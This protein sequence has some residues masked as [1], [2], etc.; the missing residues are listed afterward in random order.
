MVRKAGHPTL[1]KTFTSK[2]KAQ[3]WAAGK[4]S[5]IA[6]GEIFETE[7]RNKLSDAIERYL[8]DPDRNVSKYAKGVLK[9]WKTEAK[10]RRGVLLGNKKLNRLRRSD[11]IEAR[12][13]LK[14]T[15]SRHGNLL[16]PATVN[17]RM[18]C[19][20]AVLTEAQQ[21]DWV[22][23]NVARIRRIPGEVQRDRLMTP[24]EQKLLLKACKTSSEPHMY[25]FVVCAMLSGARAGE[26]VGLRWKDI[27]LDR[28]LA[29]LLNT[30]NG[31]HRPVPIR[32]HALE[33]VRKMKSHEKVASLRGDDFVFKNKTGY[34]PFYYR[35][36]WCEIRNE[37][38][39]GD[40]RF[41]DLRHLA[42]S[43]LAMAGATQR[44]LMEVLGHKS[45]A[46][47]Q[48]YSH[49]FDQHIADLGDRL[50]VRLFGNE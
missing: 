47:T 11:F 42:A 3:V 19:I 48:R 28:G 44:E 17:R 50:Q 16:A 43:H 9:W 21:W 2:R 26:L 1:T 18:S 15:N 25:A 38:K 4:E 33:L 34:A 30:K 6:E 32:G 22:Q 35:K 40:F 20:S 24:E 14:Q 31:T 36:V 12:D 13:L 27:D 46:M 49:F 10:N 41:H 37:A 45:A 39:L 23:D 7:H 5:R 29:R 8:E